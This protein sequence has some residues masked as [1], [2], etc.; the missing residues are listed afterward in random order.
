MRTY[1]VL[2]RVATPVEGFDR[3]HATA[4]AEARVLSAL[5]AGSSA[6]ASRIVPLLDNEPVAG[7]C[8][9]VLEES[10]P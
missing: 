4:R 9:V 2:L 6:G 10:R 5:P 7:K 3:Q 8:R 1:I